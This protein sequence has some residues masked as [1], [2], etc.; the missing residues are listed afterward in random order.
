MIETRKEFYC[1]C[2]SKWLLDTGPSFLWAHPTQL[3]FC[4][5]FLQCSE[6]FVKH[7]TFPMST[8]FPWHCTG[9]N[10]CF[11]WLHT[12]TPLLREPE[13]AD[14]SLVFETSS[15][16]NAYAPS[17]KKSHWPPLHDLKIYPLKGYV[18]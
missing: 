13:M 1:L 7:S 8:H 18:L 9:F 10:P 2:L 11:A 4:L 14:G 15:Q 17:W 5:R 6:L 16:V 3:F 12:T